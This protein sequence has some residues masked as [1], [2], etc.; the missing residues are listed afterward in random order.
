[1]GREGDEAGLARGQSAR[2]NHVGGGGRDV[3]VEGLLESEC[4]VHAGCGIDDYEDVAV[5][6]GLELHGAV[7]GCELPAVQQSTTPA[8]PQGVV[9]MESTDNVER[10]VCG[11]GGEGEGEGEGGALQSVAGIHEGYECRVHVPGEGGAA[12]L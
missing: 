6:P 2:W 4:E 5:L 3:Q 12:A 9:V 10:N 7:V 11:D 8:I 1:M